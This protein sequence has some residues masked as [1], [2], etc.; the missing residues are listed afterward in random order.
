[1]GD[2]HAVL[3]NHAHGD[4]FGTAMN[5]SATVGGVLQAGTR[6]ARFV[7]LVARGASPYDDGRS[8]FAP[9][10]KIPVFLPLSGATIE[11]DGNARCVLGCQTV[12]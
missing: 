9:R 2:V 1:L 5:E 6:T 3:L 8:L 10:R 4:H 11:F 7:E 12:G